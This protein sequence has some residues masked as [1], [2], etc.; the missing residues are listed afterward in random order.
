MQIVFSIAWQNTFQNRKRTAAALGGIAFSLLLVFIQLGFLDG[1]KRMSTLLY[2]LFDFDLAVVSSEYQFMAIAPAFDHIRLAQVKVD[3]QV[4]QV[5]R[6]N[7]DNSRWKDPDTGLLSQMLLI[8]LDEQ[9]TFINDHALRIGLSTLK[10]DKS[11]VLDRFSNADFGSRTVG[12]QG[13]I[14]E[15]SVHVN[16]LFQLGMFFFADGAVATTNQNFHGLSARGSQQVSVGL[17]RLK[18]GADPVQAASRIRQLLPV[19]VQ[20]LT[21]QALMDQ[22]QAYFVS[23]KPVGIM[24]QAGVFVAYAV[25]LVILFQVLST[26]LGNRLNEFA[27]LKAMGFPNR[28]IY[29]IGIVQTLLFGLF[30]FFPAWLIASGVFELIFHFSKLPMEMN[31]SLMGTVLGLTLIMCVVSGVLALG[32]VQ[33]ADPADLY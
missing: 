4:D 5:F 13:L 16:A 17:I 3:S 33:G 27:T 24:F 12:Q 7:I 32:K 29:G 2:S 1:A 18:P 11:V 31:A 19:E 22:E 14:D 15:K 21:H 26:E 30:S 8:G 6:L 9:P 28:T 23:V 25:G 20:I 10:D